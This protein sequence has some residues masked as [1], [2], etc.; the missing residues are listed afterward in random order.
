MKQEAYNRLLRE[1]DRKRTVTL[2]RAREIYGAD[3]SDSTWKR[4]KKTLARSNG[5]ALRWDSKARVFRVPPTWTLYPEPDLDPGKRDRLAVLRAAAA[6]VG[7]PLTDQIASFIEKLDRQLEQLDPDAHRKSPPRQPEPRADKAFFHKLNRIELAIR[8]RNILTIKYRKSAGGKLEERSIAPY[9][10]HNYAGRFYVWGTDEGGSRPKFFALDRIEEVEVDA[11]DTFDRD[12][13]LS[14]DEEL[15][16]SFGVWV[17]TGKPQDI[18]VEVRQN[19]AADVRARRWPAEKSCTLLPDGRLRIVFSVTDPREVVAWVL[20]FGGDA[21]I[22]RPAAVARLA[23]ELGQKASSGHEWARDV[24][25]DERL[26]RFEWG[27][28]GLPVERKSGH[29]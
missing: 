22:R 7:P 29:T 13:A 9:E 6:G 8:R 14:L 4:L 28:D 23:F 16:N 20:S 12:P 2:K 11:N 15:R 25:E 26:L 27:V 3:F 17:G 18:E 24:P 21:W 10:L 19:R 5:C 1:L